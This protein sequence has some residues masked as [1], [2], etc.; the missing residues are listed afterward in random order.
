MVAGPGRSQGA[1]EGEISSTQEDG[2][3]GQ[4]SHTQTFW[5]ELLKVS[6]NFPDRV[7]QVNGVEWA[8]NQ[9]SEILLFNVETTSS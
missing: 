4:T 6:K 5:A 7:F 2:C 3:S 9:K 1:E 8:K